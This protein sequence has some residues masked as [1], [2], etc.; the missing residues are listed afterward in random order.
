MTQEVVYN[1]LLKKERQ[2]I[3]ER[4]GLVMER[5]FQDRL[6]EFSETL[7]FHFAK[8]ESIRKAVDYL[9]Q[10]GEKSLKRYAVEESHQYF[11]EAFDILASKPERTHE[12]DGLLIDLLIKWAYVFYYRGDFRGLLDLFRAHQD[13][14]ESVDDR[15][16][17]GM[18]YCR[19]AWGLHCRERCEDSYQYLCK[20][21]EIGEE[22]DNP[23]VIGYACAWLTWTCTELGRLDE[24]ITH[25]ERA[26]TIFESQESDHYLYFKSLAGMGHAYLYKGERKKALEAGQALLE[27]GHK[28]SNIRGMVMGH[29]VTGYSHMIAG[30]F[31][32]AIESFQKGVQISAD[33]FY[34]QMPRC[35]LGIS[36]LNDGQHQEAEEELREVVAY[37]EDFGCESLGTPAQMSLASISVGKGQISQGLKALEEGLPVI[38]E[39]RGRSSYALSQNILGQVYLQILERKGP[40]SLSTMARNI[41]FLV[42]DLPLASKKAEDHLN[43]SIKAA[44]EIGANMVLGQAYLNLGFLHR[45]SGKRDQARECL[46]AAIQVLEQCEAEVYLRKAKEALENL[47]KEGR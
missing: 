42:K 40:I 33:P 17:L 44:R 45:A 1:G 13:L 24:A 20:S 36:Y 9:M 47:D 10:S 27:F 8:A 21:L 11:K 15:A 29:Y 6:S 30:D 12:E 46:A 2:A 14:A 31:P 39:N 35:L 16:K 22:I 32:S 37:S 7:A 18:F 23:H 41:G 34:T 25:G 5:L 4:I 43:E 28:H 19:L 38:L 26:Q 3:H